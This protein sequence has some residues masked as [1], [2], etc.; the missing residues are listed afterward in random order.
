M[1]NIC[2]MCTMYYM[3]VCMF[4]WLFV[5]FYSCVYIELYHNTVAGKI[6]GKINFRKC[7]P[8]LIDILG[9]SMIIMRLIGIV[10]GV[11]LSIIISWKSGR[12]TKRWKAGELE[13]ERE[14]GTPNWETYDIH[15]TQT[16]STVYSIHAHTNICP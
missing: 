4:V 6:I 14:E 15:T 11:S 3:R 8:I 10:H 16:H 2:G 13:R 7:G 5:P 1:Y 12:W 9:N